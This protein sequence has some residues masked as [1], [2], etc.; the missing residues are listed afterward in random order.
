[1]AALAAALPAG[2]QG[3]TTELQHHELGGVSSWLC[4]FDVAQDGWVDLTTKTFRDPSGTA[5]R[6][7]QHAQAVGTYVGPTGLVVSY[8]QVMNTRVELMTGIYTVTGVTT[9]L[10]APDA[11]VLMNDV[12]RLVVQPALPGEIPTILFSA[13]QHP[14]WMP[15]AWDVLCTYL[16]GGVVPG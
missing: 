6:S 7:E 15:G 2:A 10:T 14:T 16:S 11:G 5:I 4:G 13:G 9:R 8:D 12:G 1:M 3:P